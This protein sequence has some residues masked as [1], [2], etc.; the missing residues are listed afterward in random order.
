MLAYQNGKIYQI[1]NTINDEVYVGSTCS[2]LSIRMCKHRY[3]VNHCNTPVYKAFKEI[4]VGNLLIELIEYYPCNTKEELNRREG[5]WIRKIGTLN[6]MV[7]GRTTA[8]RYD[9]YAGVIA[10]T[11][12]AK[13]A[14]DNR[15]QHNSNSRK[16]CK[17]N[18]DMRLEISR[19]SAKKCKRVIPCDCGLRVDVKSLK[20]HRES[21]VHS[22]LL[23]NPDE[24][25]ICEC[26][27]V[28]DIGPYFKNSLKRHLL[29]KKHLTVCV[30]D[31]DSDYEFDGV[32]HHKR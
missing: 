16:W 21:E 32:P 14:I 15:E 18:H 3:Y 20:I 29:S 6:R 24:H 27:Q 5:E 11:R 12:A 8:E 26:G 4:G 7:A 17:N 23:R 30:L 19:K 25:H 22:K 9:E 31:S 28:F 1:I 2:S 10:R 13:W